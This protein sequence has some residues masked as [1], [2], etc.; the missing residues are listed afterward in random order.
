MLTATSGTIATVNGTAVE[1]TQSSG[2]TPLALTLDTVTA[3]GGANGIVLEN[4]S[5]TFTVN[6]GTIQNTTGGDGAVAGNGIYLSGVTGVSLSSMTLS[7][8]PNHAIRGFD[9]TGFTLA[10]S[11]ITGPNGNNPGLD[12]GSVRFDGLFGTA[13]ITGT[14]IE[15]G[16]KDNVRVLNTSG[17]A[18]NLAVTGGTIGL[19]DATNGNDGILILADGTAGVVATVTAVQ[20]LGARSDLFQANVLGS[21]TLNVNLV[22]NTFQNGH[23]NIVSGG[24]GVTIGGGDAGSAITVTYNVSGTAPGL[25]TF[26]GA[27]GNALTVNFVNGDGTA[28]G[29]IQN[30]TIGQAGVEGSASTE[31]SGISVGT[32]STVTHT[33]TINNNI[34]RGV[35][36]TTPADSG[37]AGIDAVALGDS[38]LNVTMTNNTI[39]EL[40][41]AVL[42]GI[43]LL[44]GSDVAD[45]ARMCANIQNNTV[46]A[47][48]ATSPLAD[49]FGDYIAGT[50]G[51][52]PDFPG[53]IGGL[54]L[55]AFLAAQN[56]FNGLGADTATIA[57]VNTAAVCP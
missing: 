31:G 26:Q 51:F 24:G 14:L 18:L 4:T 34:I 9:V 46:D 35:G 33:A 17:P 7:N 43:Y 30:N 41:G 48:G 36:T 38:Q 11:T 52:E 39:D 8:H 2:T 16:I 27:K 13:S 47:S 3:N 10:N 42:A 53:T 32:A 55:D 23:S 29:T 22:D 28:T 12:E 21:A 6:G 45:T 5:G 50:Y 15:G 40:A 20:F 57:S 25:Q 37:F 44:T 49:L 19:N 1:I 56:T 54:A